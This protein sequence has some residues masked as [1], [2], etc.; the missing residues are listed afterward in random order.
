[1]DESGFLTIGGLL[2]LTGG[3]GEGALL[4]ALP[5]DAPPES[6]LGLSDRQFDVLRLLI[7]GKPNKEI[8]R[9]LVLSES[10]VKTHLS[11]IFRKL[12]VNSRTQAVVAVA[13]A[14]VALGPLSRRP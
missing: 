12:R 13:R 1:M 14:G 2:A 8:C 7:E 9:M 5:D 11:A 10:T 3:E 6:L 4:S